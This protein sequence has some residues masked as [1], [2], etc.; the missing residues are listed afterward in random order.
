MPEDSAQDPALELAHVLF[1]DI[2]AYSTLPMDQQG[3]CLGNLQ[4]AVKKTAEF[5]RAEAKGALIRL[6]TGDGMALVFFGDPEAPARC[7]LE[8]SEMLRNEPEIR[9]RMG[10]HTGPVYRIMDINANGNVAG[11]GINMAQRVMDCGDANHILVSSAVAEVLQQLSRW[12]GALHD[13]GQ[14][15]VKHGVRLR[16]YN[17]FTENGGNPEIPK[18]IT[19][20]T[21]A[22]ALRLADEASK[23]A[24]PVQAEPGLSSGARMW[25]VLTSPKTAFRKL[26]LYPSWWAPWLLLS[27]VAVVFAVTM[28]TQVGFGPMVDN[29]VRQSARASARLKQLPPEQRTDRLE[30]AATVVRLASYGFPVLLLLG[31]MLTSLVLMS[32]F[33][34]AAKTEI[35]FVIAL[36]VVMYSLIPELLR[37]GVSVALLLA[38][39]HHESFMWQ[40]PL[41]TNPAYFLDPASHPLLYGLASSVDVFRVWTVLLAVI[42]FCSVAKMKRARTAAIVAAWYILFIVVGT[43]V[44][45]VWL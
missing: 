14:V 25:A 24:I 27:V 23:T 7:A 3:K 42:G 12:S 5:N 6:P 9:L 40:N 15:Q 39:P 21:E 36:A 2:V 44:Q 19:L 31:A 26:E 17:L 22:E 11:G 16:V 32:V 33:K 18:K 8:L 35:S 1:M 30:D 20:A 38:T 37:V 45:A 4:C 13:L 29:Q 10:I 41:P 34:L 43:G 28:E